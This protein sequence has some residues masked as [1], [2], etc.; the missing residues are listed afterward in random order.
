MAQAARQRKASPRALTGKILAINGAVFVILA[1]LLAGYILLSLPGRAATQGSVLLLVAEIL[2]SV[3][4]A[5]GLALLLVGLLLRVL[6]GESPAASV[7]NRYYTALENQDYTTA[8]QCLAPFMSMAQGQSFSPDWF[9]QAARASDSAQGQVTNYA[10]AGVQANPG[11]RVYTI[12]VTRGSGSYRTRL[13]LEKQGYDWKI[14][15][16]DRF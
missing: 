4:G 8:I 2:A 10:L 3:F 5:V 7:V 13:R 6:P 9:I 14:A 15:G 1:A 12:K 11:K 16:F